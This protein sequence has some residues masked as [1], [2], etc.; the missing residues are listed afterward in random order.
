MK[1]SAAS[2][3]TRKVFSSPWGSGGRSRVK[4]GIIRSQG[5]FHYERDFLKLSPNVSCFLQ[6]QPTIVFKEKCKLT[7]AINAI[8]DIC[9]DIK[10]ACQGH[11]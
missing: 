3:F 5:F 6:C 4:R 11:I 2:W 8:P 1:S 10:E 9:S 7:V